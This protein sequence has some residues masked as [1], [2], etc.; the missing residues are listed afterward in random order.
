ML[1]RRILTAL[2]GVPLVLAAAWVGGGPFLALLAAVQLLALA[3]GLRLARRWGLRPLP[4]LVLAS[5]LVL[6]LALHYGR[7]GGV[8]LALSL[9]LLCHLVACVLLFPGYRP[10]DA[11]GGLLLSCYAALIL[12]LYALRSL[13]EGR[14]WVLLVLVSTWASDTVAYFVG[15]RVGRRP[16][17][18]RLSPGKTVEGAVGGVLAAAMAA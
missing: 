2:W 17:W 16:L 8:V 9:L 5:G 1:W 10:A 15:R 18:A 12:Y 4:W 14:A 6:P 13:P 7:V 11:A 3:E